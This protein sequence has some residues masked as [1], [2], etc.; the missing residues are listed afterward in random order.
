MIFYIL[1]LGLRN[2]LIYGRIDVYRYRFIYAM[3]ID[4]RCEV[5]R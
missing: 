2:V 3:H 1:I 4:I 5:Q